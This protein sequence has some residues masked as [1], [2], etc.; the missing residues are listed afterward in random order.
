MKIHSDICVIGN[1]MIGK[2]SALALARAGYKVALLAP[3]ISEKSASNESQPLWDQRVYA[4]NHVA[5]SLLSSLKVW[6]AMDSS[7]IAP[8]DAMAV[9]GDDETRPGCLG[10]NAYG[11]RVG[12][13]AWIVE[14]SNLNRALDS[15][16]SFASGVN[17]IKGRA[18]QLLHTEHHVQVML[19]DGA[20]L[21]T[22]LI[23]GADGANSWVRVQ[24]D[25]SIDYRSYDQSAV[26]A[27]FSC[28]NAHHGIASQWFLGSDGIV[29]LLPL[30]DQRVS[31]VWSAPEALAN[32]LMAESPEKLCE[33]LFAL[34]GQTL[35]LFEML[36]PSVPKS[37][38]LRL[39]RSHSLI[40]NRIALVGDAAHV[41]H[42]LAGQGMNLGF[43][44]VDA[45]VSVLGQSKDIDCGDTRLLNRYARLR[46]E[47]ILLM[48]VT[49]DGLYRLFSSDLPPVKLL[50][51]AGMRLIDKIP[52]LKNHLA[53]QALGHSYSS[54]TTESF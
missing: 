4:L 24:A 22:S 39:I 6:D 46:A 32:R 53:R 44:D 29:A 48:Q 7:R 5:K 34:P 42:P 41:V 21:T 33:R 35:G 26:V 49:T 23:I 16:L 11:A 40:A 3:E 13:L 31:L 28:T 12:A 17:F 51:N 50:R 10:F 36:P 47:D 15:A 20:E 9:Q 8:V 45:L 18:D 19:D 27:N 1:G 37:F 38:P 14:D 2:A 43:A 25:T 30:P 52:F 54:N